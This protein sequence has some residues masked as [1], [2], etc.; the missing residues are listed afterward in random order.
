[1]HYRGVTFNFG[2]AKECSPAIFETCLSYEKGTWIPATDYCMYFYIMVLF[3]VT[4]I[5]Q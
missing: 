4:A 3:P 5:L 2:Y 1:M